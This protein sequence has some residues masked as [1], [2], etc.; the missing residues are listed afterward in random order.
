MIEVNLLFRNEKY[1]LLRNAW[2]L[3]LKIE[4]L[5]LV[6]YQVSTIHLCAFREQRPWLDYLWRVWVKVVKV[7]CTQSL[8]HLVKKMTLIALLVL[9]ECINVSL[10][11]TTLNIGAFILVLKRVLRDIVAFNLGV[12]NSIRPWQDRVLIYGNWL[13][14]VDEDV[15][16]VGQE[17]WGIVVLVIMDFYCWLWD[18]LLPIFQSQIG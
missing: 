17:G 16:I 11:K 6:L 4:M 3:R 1:S 15:V 10:T 8:I 18:P 12:I 9:Y 2:L 13:S 14:I 7:I 5:S